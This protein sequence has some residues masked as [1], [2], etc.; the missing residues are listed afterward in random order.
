MRDFADILITLLYICGSS[1]NAKIT[2]ITVWWWVNL[3]ILNLSILIYV[4]ILYSFLRL[5][6]WSKHGFFVR[7]L[8][9]ARCIITWIDWRQI[10]RFAVIAYF[11]TVIQAIL[12][13]RQSKIYT[14]GGANGWARYLS[15]PLGVVGLMQIM[16]CFDVSLGA[17]VDDIC[18][19]SQ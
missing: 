15:S 18:V 3:P 10:F 1:I 4:N 11:F 8:S 13:W 9:T 5:D 2:G 17:F 16:W 6:M 19:R 12:L 7:Y 14:Y